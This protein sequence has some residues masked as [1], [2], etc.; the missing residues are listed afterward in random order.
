VF[1]HFPHR[2][3]DFRKFARSAVITSAFAVHGLPHAQISYCFGI[4]GPQLAYIQVVWQKL[5]P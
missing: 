2:L 5:R 1:H 3:L 4:E